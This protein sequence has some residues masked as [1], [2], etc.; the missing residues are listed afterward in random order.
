[1]KSFLEEKL[2]WKVFGKEKKRSCESFGGREIILKVLRDLGKFLGGNY[3]RE[4]CM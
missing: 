2:I 1:M 4:V 3:F